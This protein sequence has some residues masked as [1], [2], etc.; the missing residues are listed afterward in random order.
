M[1]PFRRVKICKRTSAIT[2]L[3][4]GRE[5]G[6]TPQE[7]TGPAGCWSGT[8]GWHWEWLAPHP[9]HRFNSSFLTGKKARDTLVENIMEKML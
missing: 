4:L 9:P 5:A 6:A 1:G 7:V 3:L 2:E 8:N